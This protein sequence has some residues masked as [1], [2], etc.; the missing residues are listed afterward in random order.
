MLLITF[1][2]CFLCTPCSNCCKIRIEVNSEYFK[3]DVKWPWKLC[4]SPDPRTV[5]V[6]QKTPWEYTQYGM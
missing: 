1:G 2:E 6:H 5:D 3:Q 4:L